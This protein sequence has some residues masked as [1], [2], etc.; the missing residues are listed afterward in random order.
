MKCRNVHFLGHLSSTRLGEEMR[1][2]DL[3]FFPSVI[4]GHPQVLGQ[5][6]ACGLPVVAMNLYRPEFVVHEKTGFLAGSDEELS[7]GLKRLLQDVNLR[8]RFSEAAVIHSRR[9]DWDEVTKCWESAFEHVVANQ[10]IPYSDREL[11]AQAQPR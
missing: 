6:A 2:A 5:A 9:F 1:Q 3:F 10:K 7:N 11:C 8:Q 4:E